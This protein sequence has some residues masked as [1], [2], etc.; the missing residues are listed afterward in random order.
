MFEHS[1]STE[2]KSQKGGE[3]KTH[4]TKN[5]AKMLKVHLFKEEKI[6]KI[7]HINKTRR[8]EL[9]FAVAEKV[10]VFVQT[11]PFETSIIHS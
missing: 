2:G 4:S 6:Q 11:T 5:Q 10:S 8:A 1:E 3:K 7:Q 9:T